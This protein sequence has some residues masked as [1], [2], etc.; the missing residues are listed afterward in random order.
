[1][2]G[3]W[4]LGLLILG[5]SALLTGAAAP[6]RAAGPEPGLLFHLSADHGLT[7]DYS[8]AG[9]PEPNFASEVTVIPDG[10]AGPGLQCGHTQL[11]SYWAPGNIYAQRG[12]L[13]FFWRSREPVGPTAFPIFRVGYAD[14]SSWD[15]VWLRIDYNGKSGFD[16]FVTDANLARTR[17]SYAL[18]VFPR[19]SAW[20]HL[21]LTW[22]ETRG[23]RFYVNGRLAGSREGTFRFDAALD[24]FG[25]HSRIISPYQVQSAYNF[26]RGGDIDEVRIYDRML[27]DSGIATLA[28]GHAPDTLPGL[29]RSL[30]VQEW[31]RDWWHRYGWNRPGDAPPPAQTPAVSIRKVEIH[32][33][34]DLNRWTWKG[35][36]GIRETTWPGVY[37]RSRLPGRHDYFVLPDWDCYSLSGKSVTFVMPDEPW[38]QVEISGAAWGSTALVAAGDP[39]DPQAPGTALFER[40]RGQE[41]TY[42]RLPAAVHGPQLRFTNTEQ[43]TPIGELGAYYVSSNR[44][45]HGAG[46]LRYRLTAGIEPN[47]A[48]VASI[49]RFIEGRHPAEE[50]SV[51]VA[52]PAGAPRTVRDA[53]R[54]SLPLVHILVP[55]D[56]RDSDLG[57]RRAQ[58]T[59]SWVNMPAGLDGIAIDLPALNVKPTHGAYFPLNIQVKD[60]IWPLRNLMDVSLSVRPGEPHTIWLDTR[61]RI[62][63][64]DRGLYLT[65]AG[66]GPD[67]GPASLEGAE[68]RLVFKARQDTLAE[69]VADRFTQVRDNYAFLV[70]ESP[71]S[72]RLDLFNRWEGDVTDLLRADPEHVLGQRYWYD[73]NREQPRPPVA[74]AAVPA[75]VPSWAFRQIESLRYVKRFVNWYIDNRQI[76]NGEFGGGLS[77]DGDLTNYWPPLAF[78]GADPDKVRRSLLREMDAFYEQGLFTNGLSTIQADEL[79]SYEEGIDVLG[80]SML[81]DH[82]SPKQIE[83]AMETAA[84]TERVTG[85]NAAGHRHIRSSYFSGT[86]IATEGV[87]G[88]S[89]G[90]SY[91]ILHPS[92]ALVDFNG[93]PAVRQWLLELADGA[94]AHYKPDATG[95]RTVRPTVEFSSDEDLPGQGERAWPLLWAAFRW[96]GDRRY[97]QPFLDAG[98]RGLPQIS[99][100]ALD[101]MGTREEWAP[102]I[103]AIAAAQP[104]HGAFRY[105]AWQ[106]SGDLEHLSAMYADQAAAAA[107]REYINTEGSLWIDR[108]NVDHAELQ[109]T[110]LGGVALVR[111]AYVPGHAVSWRFDA[112]GGDERVAILV[113]GATPDRVQIVAYNLDA[114]PVTARM[115][116][117]DVA[118]GAWDVTQGTRPLA[119]RGPLENAT[120]RR[121]DLGR[122][123]ELPVTFAPRTVTAIELRLVSKGTPYWSRP[124]LGIGA[125]DVRVAGRTMNVTVHSLGAA[126]APASRVVLR[127]RAGREIARTPVPAM[128]APRDLRPRKSTV[129]LTLP[130][131]AS[132]TG[133]SITVEAPGGAEEITQKNNTVRF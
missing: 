41:R 64:N 43:E 122:S 74:L 5:S 68:I 86:T 90:S 100:N 84:A 18:P 127:D 35:T 124:D 17:V 88:W 80:Q 40:P 32:D 129:A 76:E 1:M 96:T 118:P 132:W 11:L 62:L 66:A 25:P 63:P 38:N 28:G 42:H 15:M 99:A 7:A 102:Q 58:F 30:A 87:W 125:D 37:N 108:V 10:A 85:V 52:M 91:L 49:V 116:L 133:G 83:R 12:T 44:E 89:K 131:G 2:R 103:M 33:A 13:S 117:W 55:S 31:Q 20:T 72:R 39:K 71:R 70:E 50:R 65:I 101:M 93:A 109:R 8:A 92:I 113:P 98:P 61:D 27:A 73:Y 3:S 105:L 128:A 106:V 34:Y 123:S 126:P 22:D 9:T 4:R 77:D 104:G 23:M 112:P 53:A 82:G 24:Q 95:A 19:P 115:T 59:Y 60:P 36:D 130:A 26:A 16:A 69:H 107:L 94:L 46:T 78:M 29:A 67:F 120:T 45:P 111:N 48:S 114:A 75:N 21:A 51:L 79:H 57:A 119:E 6:P 56:F 47:Q 14:H 54:G 121:A 81:L 110:R 97:I